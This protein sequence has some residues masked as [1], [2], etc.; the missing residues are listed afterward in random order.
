VEYSHQYSF[1][2]IKA[3]VANSSVQ[4]VEFTYDDKVVRIENE[5]PYV[6]AGKDG[7]GVRRWLPSPGRHTL[8][9]SAYSQKN[10]S[11]VLLATTT[12]TFTAVLKDTEK[13]KLLKVRPSAEYVNRKSPPS[14]LE[15]ALMAR[16]DM[17]GIARATVRL[18]TYNSFQNY[19]DHASVTVR[20]DD[21][22]VAST[23]GKPFYFNV[24]IP[25]PKDLA[26]GFY[27][28][29]VEAED[30]AGN[31][32]DVAST[33]WFGEFTDVVDRL[34]VYDRRPELLNVVATNSAVTVNTSG[35]PALVPVQITLKDPEG[36]S[37]CVSA[38]S[39]GFS[40]DDA[41]LTEWGSTTTSNCLTLPEDRIRGV[42]S[43]M[44]FTL[45]MRPYFTT[46]RY[47]LKVSS[48]DYSRDAAFLAS[49]NFTSYI[50]LINPNVKP[51]TPP[52]VKSLTALSSTTI[53]LQVSPVQVNVTTRLVLEDVVTGFD[54][55]IEFW[56]KNRRA[57]TVSLKNNPLVAGQQRTL[58]VGLP[59]YE[60]AGMYPLRLVFKDRFSNAANVTADDLAQQG[61]P[62][63]VE[64]KA[65]TDPTLSGL[66]SLYLSESETDISFGYRRV[67]L[68][69]NFGFEGRF[70][71][72]GYL[73]LTATGAS[74]SNRGVVLQGVNYC[75]PRY[76]SNYPYYHCFFL[77]ESTPLGLYLISGQAGRGS[78]YD[79]AALQAAGFSS[80]FTVT[81][82][83]ATGLG[84]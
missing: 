69:Y 76:G 35:L 70:L 68:A 56:L 4:S 82:Y 81:S 45:E 55:V 42:P 39:N 47:N 32:D 52:V 36:Y 62:I 61:Y 43:V 75:H 23:K 79:T 73:N 44:N 50:D 31:V 30:G 72:D 80:N 41:V 11:G 24:S 83:I 77:N 74:D 27:R 38:S 9:A 51:L 7:N 64:V 57:V 13:P 63:V 71:R 48:W 60:R 54:G 33:N 78:S 53:D 26:N 84:P 34:T 67:V 37:V 66:K 1:Y 29:R 46:G 6:L 15:L 25:Y 20:F 3:D 19:T 17:S 2:T 14:T 58:D 8:V 5:A 65:T 18:S 12:V 49:K 22:I 40:T 59:I 10:A 21:A 16:D 28:Y